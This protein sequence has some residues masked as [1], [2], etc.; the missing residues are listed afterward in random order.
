MSDSK[1]LK[2]AEVA[3]RVLLGL[4]FVVFGAMYF[5]MTLPEPDLT[6]AGGKYFAGLV[7]AVFFLPFLK[8][9]EVIAGLML[10]TKRWTALA[11][12]V[13]APII[14]QIVLY[15]IFLSPGELVMGA[16]LVA[17]AAFLAWRNWHKYAALFK[18]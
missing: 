6:T 10:F 14:L 11:L 13:L 2:Y 3:A 18:A 15:E 1:W 9:V 12:L 16:V 5:F 17:L 8:G 4:V 7:A